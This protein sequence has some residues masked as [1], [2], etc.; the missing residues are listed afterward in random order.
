MLVINVKERESPGWWGE[1]T[2]VPSLASQWAWEDE[3]EKRLE[4]CEGGSP[5][6]PGPRTFQAEGLRCSGKASDVEGRH[7]GLEIR[8][9]RDWAGGPSWG[10]D[11]CFCSK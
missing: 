5:Q 8:L 9:K 7:M 10:M 11:F 1:G 2:K 3:F 6:M 4:G